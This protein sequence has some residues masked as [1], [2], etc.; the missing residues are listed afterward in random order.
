MKLFK[1]KDVNLWQSEDKELQNDILNNFDKAKKYM[2]PK[3]RF[4]LMQGNGGRAAALEN[5]QLSAK[6]RAGGDPVLC[7]AE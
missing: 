4:G 2:L 5:R 6:A 1:V 7:E 3:V